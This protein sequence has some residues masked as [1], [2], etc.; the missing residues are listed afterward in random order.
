MHSILILLLAVACSCPTNAVLYTIPGTKYG[1]G[2]CPAPTVCGDCPDVRPAAEPVVS[3]DETVSRI[4]ILCLGFSFAAIFYLVTR[5]RSGTVL[6]QKADLD[7]FSKELFQGIYS[8]IEQLESAAATRRPADKIEAETQPKDMP[9]DSPPVRISGDE[10]SE[11]LSR[12]RF[13]E[14]SQDVIAS[15]LSQ[16][17]AAFQKLEQNA[18][19]SSDNCGSQ[20]NNSML[21]AAEDAETTVLDTSDSILI[22][23]VDSGSDSDPELDSFS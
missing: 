4:L 5:Q 3:A 13:M 15:G 19:E 20:D 7:E 12:L 10:V 11:I 22:P 16:L 23:D 8:A 6:Y 2:S 1:I 9:N 17:L 21:V 18:S 14:H